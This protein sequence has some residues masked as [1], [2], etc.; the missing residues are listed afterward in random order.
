MTSHERAVEVDTA[1]AD[2]YDRRWGAL[3][4][5]AAAMRNAHFIVRDRQITKTRWAMTDDEALAAVRAKIEAMP[6]HPNSRTYQSLLDEVARLLDVVIPEVDAQITPLQAEYYADPW[7]RFF[8]VTNH[9]GH[10]HTS[11]HCST[12]H[13]TTRYGWLPALSGLT[14]AEAV[15]QQGPRLCSVCYPTA[16]VEWTVGA[17]KAAQC[18]GSG[19]PGERIGRTRYGM[20]S[21]CHRSYAITSTGLIRAHKPTEETR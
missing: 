2:L 10:I 4:R 19:K 12:C 6:S 13:P 5:V 17:P 15:A 3:D 18:P 7:P 20:C 11:M 21:T 9:G 1:L 8:L 14:E 16:P